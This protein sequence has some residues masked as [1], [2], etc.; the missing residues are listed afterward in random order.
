MALLSLAQSLGLSALAALAYLA[1]LALHRLY[2]H[3]LAKFPG[4]KLAALTGW[5]EVYFDLILD[6]QFLF[7]IER[8]HAKHGPIIRIN[9]H[10]LHVKDSAF[11]G[12]IYAGA[13]GGRKTDKDASWAMMAGAPRSA[14]STPGHELHKMRRGALNPFF[15]KR[16][17][18]KLEPRISSKVEK[19]CARFR[20]L[21]GTGT[22][23]PLHVAASAFTMDVISEYCYGEEGC[24]NYMD[25]DAFTPAW[26]QCMQDVFDGAAFRRAVPWLTALLQTLPVEYVLKLMPSMEVLFG[27]QVDLKAQVEKVLRDYEGTGGKEQG[28]KETIFHSLLENEELPESEKSLHRLADEAEILVAAGSETTARTIAYTSFYVLS[29]KGVLEKLREELRRAMP[30]RNVLPSWTE[31]EK[32]PYLA[33]SLLAIAVIL[34]LL[35]SAR[36]A[37]SKKDSASLSA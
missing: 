27:W 11:F 6:G 4:P 17:V 35:M 29:T 1:L 18:G 10:E 30:S 20:G 28:R 22:V 23:I 34:R 37:S 25:D 24:T 14:F 26:A 13:G 12:T 15:S 7:E 8:L 36:R 16:M 5:Y 31:L 9:P 21:A 2:F 32:L 19:L 3:P 33:S